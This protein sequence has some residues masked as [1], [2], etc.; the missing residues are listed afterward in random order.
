MSMEPTA[1]SDRTTQAISPTPAARPGTARGIAG[2]IAAV[3]TRE[4]L[5]IVRDPFS[6]IFS[7]LQP[8][9]FLGLF[10]PLLSGVSGAGAQST[11][12]WFLPGVVVMITMF[13]TS[14]TGSNLQFEI[15]TGA[16]ERILATPLGR[17]ALL[18]GRAL[19]S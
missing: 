4:T 17:P 12:Q 15:M 18:I 7:L 6:L 9:V 3:W 11:L 8:L 13:G 16:F 5:T 19:K 1:L 14:M 2:D 10:A